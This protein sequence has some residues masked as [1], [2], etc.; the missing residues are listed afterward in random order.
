MT[1]DESVELHTLELAESPPPPSSGTFSEP[2]RSLPAG[3]LGRRRRQYPRAVRG[4]GRGGGGR[5]QGSDGVG[6]PLPLDRP[7]HP[8]RPLGLRRPFQAFGGG[9]RGGRRH[10]AARDTALDLSRTCLRD[11]SSTHPVQALPRDSLAGRGQVL[12]MNCLPR[13]L[14]W[15]VAW[16]ELRRLLRALPTRR[17]WLSLPTGGWPGSC[18]VPARRCRPPP[19]TS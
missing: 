5:A 8:V 16:G 18:I 1:R 6:G 2:S 4:C 3:S 12:R 7:D 10:G 19:F 9:G 13:S 11:A 14:E 17:P 15:C